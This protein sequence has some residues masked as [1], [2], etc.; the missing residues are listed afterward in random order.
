M[1]DGAKGET[2]SV[3][4]VHP[5]PLPDELL[6]SWLVRLAHANGLKVHTFFARN[7]GRE[8]QIW[9]RD[10]DKFAPDWLIDGLCAGTGLDRDRI[11]ATTLRSFEGFVYEKLNPFGNTKWIL[12]LGVYHRTRRLPGLQFCPLCLRND[13]V[14]YFRKQWRLAF[15][16]EC[17]V[18]RIAL[19]ESCSRCGAP[20]TFF[21]TELGNKG[22]VGP[23]S[24]LLCHKCAFALSRSPVQRFQWPDWQTAVE[25]RAWLMGYWMGWLPLKSP[26]IG[27]SHLG[28]EVL[29][30]VCR[31]LIRPLKIATTVRTF[32]FSIAIPSPVRKRR[33]GF[34]H[35][36]LQ[37]RHSILTRATWLLHDWP[38]RFLAAAKSQRLGRSFLLRDLGSSAPHWYERVV[39][40]N[41]PM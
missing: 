5:H 14:P 15:Y 2:A 13:P 4:P 25:F 24:L 34:E 6:S 19:C 33:V 40:G 12:P 1:P 41:T 39:R 18:H 9:T 27:Y 35:L 16:T 21:R 17:D 26:N 3:W 7:F 22:F 37:I 10:I 32:G 11:V 31:L 29:H 20:V 23:A 38:N 36:P 8:R 30:Q 28:Y